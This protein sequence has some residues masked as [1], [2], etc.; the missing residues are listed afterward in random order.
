MINTEVMSLILKKMIDQHGFQYLEDHAYDIY[1]TVKKDKL[2]EDLYARVLLICL[3]SADYKKFQQGDIDRD[4]LSAQIQDN[5]ALQK[6][7]SDQMADVFT[8]LFDDHNLGEWEE[9]RYSGLKKFC[10]KEWTFTWE[11]CSRW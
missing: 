4:T 3:L 6:D 9:N 2:V 8:K 5:C 11:G 10:E 7:M 1:E